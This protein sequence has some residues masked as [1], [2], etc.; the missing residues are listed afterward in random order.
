[1]SAA[2]LAAGP[3][4]TSIRSSRL[5]LATRSREGAP[6][7]ICAQPV[8]TARPRCWCPRSSPE[9]CAITGVYPRLGERDRRERLA[10]G[11]DLV[12]LDHDRAGGAGGD[13]LPK[14]RGA[15]HKQIV[16]AS[17]SRPPSYAVSAGHAS[18][19]WRRQWV[20]AAAAAGSYYGA[21]GSDDSRVGGGRCYWI[22]RR[23]VAPGPGRNSIS[24]GANGSP[25]R[26]QWRSA[27][28]FPPQSMW[29]VSLGGP[30]GS[31]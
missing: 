2:N 1:M 22:E 21:P 10:D 17:S 15:G 20:S 24:P 28:M 29:T 30:L 31:G 25:H 3:I 8:A 6:A 26:S 4:I 5:Y 19:N 23:G 12:W 11:S 14:P 16:P 7:L 9:R 18:G 27:P 13:P